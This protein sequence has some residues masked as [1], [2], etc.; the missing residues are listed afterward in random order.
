[1]RKRQ[2]LSV[3]V[4]AMTAN[5]LVAFP[6]YAQ[7]VDY[8][9]FQSLFGEPVTT[10]ATGTPQRVS[11][12]PVDMT[13][14]T[15]DEIRQSGSRN[16]P[17]ILSRV[18]GLDILQTGENAYSVGV[19]GF[20]QPFQPRLLVMVDGRQVLNDD[21]SR[22]IWDNLPVNIDDI[23]QI[24]VVKGASS[25]LFGSNASDGVI[26][27]ITYS[28]LYDKNTVASLSAGSQN[29]FSGDGTASTK[30][31]N[32]GGIK[33][34]V[35]GMNADEFHADTNTTDLQKYSPMKRYA[36]GNS[37]FQITPDLLANVE[38]TYSKDRDNTG[39]T[40]FYIDSEDMTS[41]SIKGG[42][43]WQSPIGII[44]SNNYVNHSFGHATGGTFDSRYTTQLVVSQLQDQF[45]VGANNL[46]QAELEY[47]HKSHENANTNQPFAQSPFFDQNVYSASGSWTWRI[48]DQLSW[49]N[50]LRGD[51]QAAQQTGTLFVDAF[52]N[53]STY[54]HVINTWSANSGLVYKPTDMDTFRATYGRGI[55]LPSFFQEGLNTVIPLGGSNYY[56]IEGN[57]ALKPTI[58]QD[59]GLGYDR[60]VPEINSTARFSLFYELNQDIVG[61]N[62]M[63]FTRVIGPNTYTTVQSANVGNS[64]GFGGEFEL[65]GSHNGFRWDGSYSLARVADSQGASN[66]VGYDGSAPK[67]HFRLLGGYSTGPWEFDANGQYVTSTDMK[68]AV[69]T[70]SFPQMPVGGYASLGGRIGYKFDDHFTVAISGTN[71]TQPKIQESPYPAISRQAFLTL[72]GKF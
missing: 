11:E 51:H 23:R 54:S 30:L 63:T 43:S 5:F 67:H 25:A 1:M 38:L 44:S 7:M 8:G 10:S 65:K 64:Q 60:K 68:R 27:I 47:R 42:L 39:N 6:A 62:A 13:I 32:T 22:T 9:S 40:S 4:C 2:L 66:N 46:L 37:V 55:Q 58:V 20:Q 28:P 36:A 57:P 70:S 52:E 29:Y 12:V 49:T 18:P 31:G 61:F 33:L 45:Q 14:I 3:A 17:Q 35:G 21:Y 19:R 41:Y 16:I 24:E 71:I 50:A 15:A 34:S 59:Y 48:N 72:T 53:N 69:S 56:D 26:N